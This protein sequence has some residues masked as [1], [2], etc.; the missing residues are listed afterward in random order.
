MELALFRINPDS[1]AVERAML[2]DPPDG[3]NIKDGYY[4]VPYFQQS[5]EA[6]FFN[7]ITYR[8]AADRPN[9]DLV[10]LEYRW[11]EVR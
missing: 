8:R 3:V 10:R 11:D 1:V 5:K 2:L 9:P 7:V 6:L 4:A